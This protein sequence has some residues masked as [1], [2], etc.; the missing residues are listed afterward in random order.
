MEVY[1]LG[2]YSFEE[3][4]ESQVKEVRRSQ[5]KRWAEIFATEVTD[6]DFSAV[7]V[8]GTEALYFESGVPQQPGFTC[9]QW[10]FMNE[11]RMFGIISVLNDGD[12]KTLLP[13][14]QEMIGSI[15]FSAETSANNE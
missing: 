10:H 2:S 1:L 11:G 13:D 4:A 7:V 8:A 6:E 5:A 12:A 3:D 14:V 15:K 9:R